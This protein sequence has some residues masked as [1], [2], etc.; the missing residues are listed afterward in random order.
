M[1][2]KSLWAGP[3][4]VAAMVGLCLLP[5]AVRSQS[6]SQPPITQ[7][8]PSEQKS[9]TFVGEIV[10]AQNGQ[11]ALLTDKQKGTQYNLDDQDKAKQFEGKDVRVEG[12]LDATTN[13]IHVSDILPA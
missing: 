4:P 12:T 8:E 5:P 10:K 9:S 13:T 2:R 6:Q 1:K 3:F 11:Y 7:Q